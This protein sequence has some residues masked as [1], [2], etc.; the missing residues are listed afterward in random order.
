MEIN[1]T[2]EMI[3]E[4]KTQTIKRMP[5]LRPWFSNVNMTKEQGHQIGF[6]GEFAACTYFGFDW[7]SNIRSDYKTI[8]PFDFMLR[9]AKVD[10]K[11]ES[12]STTIYNKLKHQQFNK[13][14]R[15]YYNHP[16]IQ[17]D[18]PYGR[19][20]INSGQRNELAKKHVVL[21]GAI[22]RDKVIKD[23]IY[24]KQLDCWPLWVI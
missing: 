8:D 23:G 6:L 4:S 10:V 9:N 15:P 24:L 11:T 20:L 7:R 17:D 3:K 14:N 12:V 13:S 5:D 19:R 22:N 1:F 21:F 16:S 2:D 18:K